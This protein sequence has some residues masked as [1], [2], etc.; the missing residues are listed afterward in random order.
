MIV[1]W[2]LATFVAYVAV[3]FVYVTT[4]ATVG[5]CFGLA[6]DRVAVGYGANILGWTWRGNHWDC[7]FGWLPLGG[8][9]RFLGGSDEDA[10]KELPEGKL[11]FTDIGTFQ[12]LVTLLSGPLS[13]LL[14]GAF[15]L[16][17]AAQCET[18]RV[19]LHSDIEYSDHQTATLSSNVELA[20]D[21]F[22]AIVRRFFLFQPLEDWGGWTAAFYQI[23]IA[24]SDNFGIWVLW[25][26]VLA[27]LSGLINLLPLGTLIGGQVCA[28]LL[29]KV[30]GISKARREPIE[31]VYALAS[32][33]LLLIVLARLV[34]A[35]FSYWKGL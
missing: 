13:S 1:A 10:D 25:I 18:P 4:I 35:D 30:L 5:S 17:A 2:M 8:Y 26:G 15:L 29:F 31:L 9:A 14:L 11:A 22:R 23:S 32:F 20:V 24:G 7:S 6:V 28:E 34:F 33:G 12:R 27:V 3:T 19:S 21:V 16:F